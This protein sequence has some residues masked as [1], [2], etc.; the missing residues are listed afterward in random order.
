MRLGYGRLTNK[1]SKV[2]KRLMIAGGLLVLPVSV[3]VDKVAASQPA[4]EQKPAR[5]KGCEPSAAPS[6]DPRTIRLERFLARLHCPISNMAADFVHAADDNQLDW[7]LLP[8]ISL[9]ESGG[10]KTYRNNN[11]FGWNNGLEPFPSL[12]AGLDV[13]ASRLGRSPLYR[14]RDSIGKLRLY[15]PDQSYV[16]KVVD[17][18]NRISPAPKLTDLLNHL[19]QQNELA[20]AGE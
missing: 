2:S 3:T 19:P 11:I 7:R 8:S 5:N 20:Y 13:V 10:G 17:V 18:M 9:I 12:R 15:N 1:L 4:P 6:T 16:A 14:N